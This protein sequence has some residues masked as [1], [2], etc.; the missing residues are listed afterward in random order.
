[1]HK[2]T[3]SQILVEGAQL[4]VTHLTN[5]VDTLKLIDET[6]QKQAE[7]LKL[8]EVDQDRLRMVVQL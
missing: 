7:V 8:K 2:I 3:A 5:D 1:M 4:T 6:K